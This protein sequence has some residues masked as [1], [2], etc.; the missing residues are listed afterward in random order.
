MSLLDLRDRHIIPAIND[1]EVQLGHLLYS[2]LTTDVGAG[3]GAEIKNLQKNISGLVSLREFIDQNRHNTGSVEQFYS[4]AKR[5]GLDV[6]YHE[7]R[8]IVIGAETK[9]TKLQEQ[10]IKKMKLK[11]NGAA[12]EKKAHQAGVPVKIK[13]KLKKLTG[14][15]LLT[16]K[17]K[18]YIFKDGGF[19]LDPE[20]TEIVF[21]ERKN[22][23][24]MKVDDQPYGIET[25][26]SHS[27]SKAVMTQIGTK[28]YAFR[29]SKA[30]Y[31]KYVELREEHG[32]PQEKE[33]LQSN[34]EEIEEMLE[35]MDESETVGMKLTKVTP[36]DLLAIHLGKGDYIVHQTNTKS[37]TA[38]GLAKDLFKAF[39]EENIYGKGKRVVGDSII[40]DH[41]I[42]VMGQLNP[43]RPKE[44]DDSDLRIGWFLHALEIVAERVEAG[45]LKVNNLYF[46]YRIGSGLAGGDWSSYHK[47]ITFFEERLHGIDPKITV[48]IIKK[49]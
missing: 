11:P 15:E 6:Q 27:S 45:S 38:M 46:P 31:Q 42:H 2:S 21:V 12:G 44:D 48:H 16:I 4:E 34:R 19:T 26:K 47:A 8:A 10:R 5:F 22:V 32:F 40:T 36:G 17:V 24:Y 9:K 25:I 39:P 35:A 30:N 23:L 33:D 3:A 13:G 37:S 41:I 7:R 20:I 14:Q 18:A 28:I 1:Q 43:G 29:M 49:D